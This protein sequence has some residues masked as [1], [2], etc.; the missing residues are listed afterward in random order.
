MNRVAQFFRAVAALLRG[1]RGDEIQWV[2]AHLSPWE[3]ALFWQMS[4][5][6]QVHAVRVSMKAAQ[7]AREEG[8][9]DEASVRALVRA[10]LLHDIGKVN[11]DIGLFDRVAVVLLKR[12]AP[13]LADALA[14]RGR[15]E[16]VHGTRRGI[17]TGLRRALYAH[18]VH[19]ERGA[20]MA[21]LLGVEEAVVELIRCHHR[22]QG[23]GRLLE[24]FVKADR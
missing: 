15:Q 1:L 21:K 19:A 8:I 7:I 5:I 10:G 3:E 22:P 24:A 4:R 16:L 9:R 17:G 2:K 18:A 13:R 12:F 14:V 11:G 23:G 20:A 6:D